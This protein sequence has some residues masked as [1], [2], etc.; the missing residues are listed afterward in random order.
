LPFIE[1]GPHRIEYSVSQ[2]RGG[3]YTY[4]RFTP[5]GL[6]EVIVPRG[7]RPNLD[8]AIRSRSS[9]IVQHYL[10]SS[11][12]LRV[13]NGNTVMFDG[14]QL[15]IVFEECREV[16]ELLPALSR[17]EV[18]V[19]ARDRSRT[20]ELVR[21]WFLRESSRYAVRRVS[22]LASELGLKYRVVDVREMRSWGYCTRGGRLSFSWQLIALPGRLR[23]YVVIHELSHLVEFNHSAQFKKRLASVCPD[24]K[25]REAELSRI[26][27][28]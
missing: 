1:I 20:R 9:W 23:D 17:R 6:L 28:A 27:A 5:D 18:I 7:R 10:E 11:K 13:F 16:E 12:N 26:V 4:F 21:R 15:R 19:K 22:E 3:R 8:E 14:V 2:G 25:D 24:Y